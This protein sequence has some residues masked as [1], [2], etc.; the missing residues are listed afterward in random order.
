MRD[1]TR[2][3]ELATEAL[4]AIQSDSSVVLERDHTVTD[5]LREIQAIAER[6]DARTGTIDPSEKHDP[7]DLDPT[8]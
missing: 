1:I 5:N 4:V 2:I 8:I 3:K 6:L 7:I